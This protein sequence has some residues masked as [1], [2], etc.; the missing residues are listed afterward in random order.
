MPTPER[1]HVMVV[2]D[3]TVVRTVL[4]D[5]LRS[6]DYRVTEIADGVAARAALR[7]RLPD[8]L[9]LDRMLPGL[10]GDEVCRA[11]RAASGTLP[12]IMLTAL[13]EVEER[14]EGLEHGA[15]DYV[16][17][18]FALAE[19]RLRIDAA[20]RRLRAVSSSAPYSVGVFR[21][22]PVR[23][24][25]RLDGRD[26]RLSTREFDFLVFLLRNQDRPIGRDEILREVW[27]WS[28]GDASTVTVHVRRLREKVEP[29]P[30][31][32]RFLHT[33]WGAGYRFTATGLTAC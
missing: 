22:D 3:D 17:K 26:I 25:V 30:A 23:R 1:T 29:D 4:A 8:V 27:G 6:G 2:E 5:Y 9:V 24:Q 28:T 33:E 21:V 15:D 18:P 11:A 10:S 19:L 20:V 7:S 13:D 12:I 16:T 14:I 32:P 31:Y